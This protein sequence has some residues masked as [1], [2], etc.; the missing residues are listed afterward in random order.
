VAVEKATDNTVLLAKQL[1]SGTIN[2]LSEQLHKIDPTERIALMKQLRLDE[3]N[4]PSLPK[5]EF[6]DNN[7]LASAHGK[8]PDGTTWQT[9][10]DST[11]GEQTEEDDT[12]SDGSR[13]VKRDGK[14]VSGTNLLEDNLRNASTADHSPYSSQELVDKADL[15]VTAIKNGQLGGAKDDKIKDSLIECFEVSDQDVN[16]AFVA[17]VDQRLAPTGYKI[18][19]GDDQPTKSATGAW[20]GSARQLN[21]IS[22]TNAVVDSM[23]IIDDQTR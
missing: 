8:D 4:N 7:Y 17:Y 13:A 19:L 9:K 20:T 22:N 6:T 15:L 3:G 11:S 12:F 10:Y 21:V 5:L 18:S 1:E 23:T 2:A 16:K 14:I